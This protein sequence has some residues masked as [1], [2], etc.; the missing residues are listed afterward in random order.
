MQTQFTRP[1]NSKYDKHIPNRKST[2]FFRSLTISSNYSKNRIV[3]GAIVPI[4]PPASLNTSK[5]LGDYWHSI[6][7]FSDLKRQQTLGISDLDDKARIL[8]QRIANSPPDDYKRTP[9]IGMGAA[10]Q[11]E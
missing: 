7:S 8:T 3:R 11:G 1:T 9:L 6:L 5:N 4:L 10:H 2:N